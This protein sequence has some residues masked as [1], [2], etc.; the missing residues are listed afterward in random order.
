MVPGTRLELVQSLGSRDFKPEN[1]HFEKPMISANYC[2]FIG[3]FV[4]KKLGN[5]RSFLKKIDK[6]GTV[7]STIYHKIK[8]QDK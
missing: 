5:I 1:G 2:D 8:G 6:A 3:F 7:L 4:P